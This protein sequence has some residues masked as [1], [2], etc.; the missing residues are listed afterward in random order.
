M[1]ISPGATR[2]RR[3]A[4]A[5]GAPGPASSSRADAVRIVRRRRD[6]VQLDRRLVDRP[7]RAQRVRRIEIALVEALAEDVPDDGQQLGARAVA[8]RQ[9]QARRGALAPRAEELDVGVA[10]AVDGLARVADE[11]PLAVGPDERVEQP[12]LQA[13]R[14]LEL[15]HEHEVE[16][17]AHGA[18]RSPSRSSSSQARSW[19]SSKSSA[20]SA[21]LR[22]R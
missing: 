8:P 1:A 6:Q 2:R 21:S 14:V 5:A 10:E 13:V 11:D 3:R 9:R 19:R 7:H 15:V 16:A 22:A 18:R 4:R 12:A 20:S 17:L